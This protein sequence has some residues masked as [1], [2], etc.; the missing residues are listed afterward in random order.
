ME[1]EAREEKE[2]GEREKRKRDDIEEGREGE[3]REEKVI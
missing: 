3:R 2:G 1:G